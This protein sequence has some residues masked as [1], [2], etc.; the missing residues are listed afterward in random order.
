MSI[1]CFETETVS[2]INC[3]KLFSIDKYY[4]VSIKFVLMIFKTSMFLYDVIVELMNIHEIKCKISNQAIS[5]TSHVNLVRFSAISSFHQYLL[6]FNEIKTLRYDLLSIFISSICC[7]I[8]DTSL[9]EWQYYF[10]VH[11]SHA[12]RKPVFGVSNKV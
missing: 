10:I 1:R 11:W 5:R 8:F 3:L 2:C 6:Q 9:L 7:D 4:C 12:V